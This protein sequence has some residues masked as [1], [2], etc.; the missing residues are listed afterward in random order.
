MNVCVFQASEF[1][2]CTTGIARFNKLSSLHAGAKT[3]NGMDTLVV[4]P[5]GLVLDLEIPSGASSISLT[6]YTD[7]NGCTIRVRNTQID[8]FVLFKIESQGNGSLI[9]PYGLVDSG[10]FSSYSGLNNGL[11]LLVI[12]DMFNWTCRTTNEGTENVP[13][14]DL[15]IVRDGKAL[16]K[17]IATYDN[18]SSL[19]KGNYYPIDDAPKFFRNLTFERT[20]DS[21][22]KTF[23]LEVN[24]QYNFGIQNLR[25][26]TPDISD[27]TTAN[28]PQYRE[29][30]CVRIMDSAC[31]SLVNI[32][33]GGSYSGQGDWGYN[34]RYENV[35]NL[36]LQNVNGDA[37]WGITGGSNVNCALL[38]HC[39]INRFDCHCYGRDFT[40]RDVTI[41]TSYFNGR[42]AYCQISSPYGTMHFQHCKFIECRPLVLESSYNAFTGFEL[43]YEDCE[44]VVNP[45]Y[46]YMVDGLCL[47]TNINPRAELS[48]KCLP[49]IFMRNCTFTI[50]S[51]VTNYSLIDFP[52]QGSSP[53]YSGTI[54]HIS[55]I[56]MENVSISSSISMNLCGKPI[57]FPSQLLQ[58]L[59]NC[60][61]TLS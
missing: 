61:F 19:P 52:V 41:R 8:K 57:V 27:V 47:D 29:D 37:P 3:S 25:I 43:V 14:M 20:A 36:Y 59:L 38:D 7:F 2:D 30:M 5:Q 44:F 39:E 49:N 9:F 42:N 17:P 54:G 50:P 24:K 32:V 35:W 60:N 45:T 31:V 23:L 48:V 58:Q 34:F 40:Y 46:R 13:R 12:E 21:E 11:Y 22:K 51:S 4:Y 15:F 26:A 6:R 18:L 33:V 56:H 53:L 1:S 28:P 10:D 55:F 16:N